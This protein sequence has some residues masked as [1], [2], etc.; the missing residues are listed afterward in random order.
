MNFDARAHQF[1]G[2]FSASL[3]KKLILKGTAEYN[4]TRY[5]N[6]L[7][8]RRRRSAQQIYSAEVIRALGDKLSISLG[9]SYAFDDSNYRDLE[10]IRNLATFSV[11]RRF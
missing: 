2:G 9:Y 5:P 6:F 11:K 7:G 1:S 4:H 10:T 8:P 3:S